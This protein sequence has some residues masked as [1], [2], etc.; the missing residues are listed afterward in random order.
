MMGTARVT[1]DDDVVASAPDARRR[2][3]SGGEAGP[4]DR[5]FGAWDTR[6]R[7]LLGVGAGGDERYDGAPVRGPRL[8]RRYIPG[9]AARRESA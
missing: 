2:E 8:T 3:E 9:G 6:R 5:G 1:A 7:R 4:G